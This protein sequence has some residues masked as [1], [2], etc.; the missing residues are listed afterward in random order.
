[1]NKKEVCFKKIIALIAVGAVVLPAA[2]CGKITN[3]G[4][5]EEAATV[6]IT[7]ADTAVSEKENQTDKLIIADSIQPAQIDIKKA[8]LEQLNKD[9]EKA[10]TVYN[11]YFYENKG[12]APVLA[13]GNFHEFDIWPT[14]DHVYHYIDGKVIDTCFTSS[15]GSAE[16][17]DVYFVEGTS[18]M[19]FRELGNSGGT[20]GYGIVTIYIFDIAKG[21]YNIISEEVSYEGDI[22]HYGNPSSSDYEIIQGELNE[23]M[24]KVLEEYLGVGYKLVSYSENM[25]TK[26][27]A[28]YLSH[29]LGDDVIA[30]NYTQTY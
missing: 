9:C 13:Y 29:T 27:C 4:K 28:D 11:A 22:V 5:S 15:T 18:A 3:Y 8:Y 25:V 16:K 6:T 2:A 20:L 17:H 12:D 24:D 26:K 7:A 23:K 30:E 10:S 21:E 14:P 1:M 19:V